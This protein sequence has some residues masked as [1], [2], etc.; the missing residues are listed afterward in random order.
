VWGIDF[1]QQVTR[2]DGS[3]WPVT[4]GVGADLAR[5]WGW[6]MKARP[7][8]VFAK[9][10]TVYSAVGTLRLVAGAR[11]IEMATD[12]GM[13]PY[14]RSLPPAFVKRFVELDNPAARAAVEEVWDCES[15][16]DD[17]IRSFVN[18]R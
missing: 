4:G 18:A 9:D 7:D 17:V 15:D 16:S 14:S 12:E 10:P 1:T 13:S 6:Y 8:G 2:P 5:R 3:S 11:E